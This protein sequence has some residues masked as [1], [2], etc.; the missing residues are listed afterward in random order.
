MARVIRA[1]QRE[2]S[3]VRAEVYEAKEEAAQIR[4]RALR[5]AEQVR[6]AAFRTGHAAGRADAMLGLV[7]V[8]A[9]RVLA[10]DA[11]ERS[12][13]QLCLRVASQLVGEALEADPTRIASIVAPLLARLR[14]AQRVVLHVHPAD[15]ALLREALGQLCK[16]VELEGL[17]ELHEEASMQRGDCVAE[18]DIGELDARIETQIAEL[19]RALEG[20]TP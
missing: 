6:A 12:A 2:A 17:V 9:A 4:A 14:R 3:I 11:A 15:A 8:A 13:V 20:E 10:I 5:E 1:Q 16:H 7:D 18:S 19:A